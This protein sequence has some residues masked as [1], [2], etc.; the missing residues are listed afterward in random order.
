MA[1]EQ[2]AAAHT[3]GSDPSTAY[4]LTPLAG[5]RS[6]TRTFAK[7]EDSPP[8]PHGSSSRSASSSDGGLVRNRE[9]RQTIARILDRSC[10]GNQVARARAPVIAG[11]VWPGLQ[12]STITWVFQR[13]VLVGPVVS[14]LKSWN[15]AL[16][17]QSAVERRTDR[18]SA[19]Y[20]DQARRYTEGK[21]RLGY[22]VLPRLI[23]SGID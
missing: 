8:I 17:T 9:P 2:D 18:W 21:G 5:A 15:S 1:A 4:A 22:A 3:G 16:G 14:A 11:S 13:T 20:A 6:K 10:G 12:P 23:R 7:I 19:Q